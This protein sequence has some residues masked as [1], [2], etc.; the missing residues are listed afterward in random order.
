MRP[1]P[2]ADTAIGVSLTDTE[3]CTLSEMTN[4]V[5]RRFTFDTIHGMSATQRDV[6]QVSQHISWSSR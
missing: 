6:F 2:S 1:L 3:L 5:V 4:S